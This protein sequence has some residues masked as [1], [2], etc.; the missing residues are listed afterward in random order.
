[1]RSAARARVM[2][3][4]RSGAPSPPRQRLGQYLL[5]R[6]VSVRFRQNPAADHK[7]SED[8]RMIDGS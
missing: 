4:R 3:V 6:C 1:V 2:L 8:L 5:Q 7:L